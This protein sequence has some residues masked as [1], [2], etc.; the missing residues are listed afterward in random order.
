MEKL[1]TLVHLYPTLTACIRTK[2]LLNSRN[3]QLLLMRFIPVVNSLQK[4][5]PIAL[6]TVLS[7]FRK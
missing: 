3:S 1:E 2:M 7:V 6:L 4:S 5:E